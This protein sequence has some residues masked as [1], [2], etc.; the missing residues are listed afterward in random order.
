M[1]CRFAESI[2]RYLAM[3]WNHVKF[4]Y[5]GCGMGLQKKYSERTEKRRRMIDW[6]QKFEVI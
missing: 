1:N 2:D 6:A 5:W 3:K 4:E